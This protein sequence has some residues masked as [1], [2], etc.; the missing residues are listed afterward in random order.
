M[1]I[2]LYRRRPP[3][4]RLAAG[5]L[6]LTILSLLSARDLY[7]G[8]ALLVRGQMK[9]GVVVSDGIATCRVRLP[10]MP[11]TLSIHKPRGWILWWKVY[12]SGT[13]RTFLQDPQ[14]PE[15]ARVE[16]IQPGSIVFFLLVA[17]WPLLWMY[18]GIVFV[19]RR[20]VRRQPAPP[21]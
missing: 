15:K 13:V 19:V 5:V 1:D 18:G 11:S 6:V 14:N 21:N 3:Y 2:S 7:R 9:T 10:D 8:G 17:P 12:P 4:L 20:S 16:P